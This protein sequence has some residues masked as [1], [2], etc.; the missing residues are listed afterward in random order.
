[1]RRKIPEARQGTGVDDA[2]S[3]IRGTAPVPGL[4]AEA[5]TLGTIEEVP[6]AAKDPVC[7]MTVEQDSAAGSSEY[8]GSTYYFCS[9]GCKK[10]FDSNPGAYTG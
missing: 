10:E 8:Q 7:G 5:G 6:M 3:Y 1:M 9:P 4:P 2:V